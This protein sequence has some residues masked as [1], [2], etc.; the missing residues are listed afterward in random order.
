MFTRQLFDTATQ[1]ALAMFWSWSSL[2]LMMM[3]SVLVSEAAAGQTIHLGML[4]PFKHVRLGW[5]TNAAAA[6]MALDRAQKEG[7]LPG[8]DVQ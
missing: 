4:S 2:L 8:I 6:S 3:L 1:P 7:L 5:E